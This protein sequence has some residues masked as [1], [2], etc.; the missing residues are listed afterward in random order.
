MHPYISCLFSLAVK[1]EEFLELKSLIAK[2][3]AATQKEPGTLVYEYSVNE[4]NTTVQYSG[5]LQGG[6]GGKPRETPPSR[7]LVSVS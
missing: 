2:I 1:P 4:E 7:H 3:V 6:F 5:T